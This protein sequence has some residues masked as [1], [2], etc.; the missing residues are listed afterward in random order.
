MVNLDNL[1]NNG[2]R[3]LPYSRDTWTGYEHIHRYLT[4][5]RFVHGKRVIDIACGEG[6]G[7]A[8]LAQSATHV[9]GIDID[10]ATIEHARAAHPQPNITFLEGDAARLTI[11]PDS[12]DVVVSFETLEHIEEQEDFLAALKVALAP[13]GLLIISTPNRHRYT[14]VQGTHNPYHKRELYLDEFT[15]LLQRHFSQV[16]IVGQ[17]LTI[18]SLIS[19]SYAGLN[20]QQA[21]GPNHHSFTT[22]VDG[23]HDYP[24][25][26]QSSVQPAY[27]IAWC[28][29]R[30][31]SAQIMND[32]LIDNSEALLKE[33]TVTRPAYEQK[34]TDELAQTQTYAHRIESDLALQMK[35][36]ERLREYI[37]HLEEEIGGHVT[38]VRSLTT[39]YEQKSAATAQIEQYAHTLEHELEQK[40]GHITEL[41]AYVHNLEQQLGQGPPVDA[42]FSSVDQSPA[43]PVPHQAVKD[44]RVAVIFVTYNS[45]A[46]IAVALEAVKQQTYPAAMLQTV[47]V[48]NHSH[49]ETVTLL[50]SHYPWVT[51]IAE[52][53]NHGFARGNN[54]A[55]RAIKADYYALVNADAVMH[56]RWIEEMVQTMQ[57]YP[58]IGVAGSKIFF[59]NRVLLQHTGGYL[60]AN[61][62]TYHTGA[63]ELDISQHNVMKDVD[64]VM[65]A[66]FMIRANVAEQLHYLPEAYFMYYEETEFCVRVRKA[67]YRVVYVPEAIAYH[68]ENFSQSKSFTDR[69]LFLY[70]RS[71]YL[72]VLRNMRTPQERR[73]YVEAERA[74]RHVSRN[75]LGKSRYLW[76]A[77]LS[78]WQLI[79]R[80][81][82]FWRS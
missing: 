16:H 18:T 21:E 66:A 14:D 59:G 81:P 26:K 42:S 75:G 50:R 67:G 71:R 48:D 15:A 82:W 70:H 78:H 25:D 49:D 73:E 37:S 5:A 79:L 55:M 36:I 29:N 62:L 19:A 43:V 39:E 69:F 41:E 2:E 17:T 68:D 38:A 6:Y 60:R 1:P 7:A 65:G 80:H 57:V 24:L 34:L 58:N 13:N 8:I 45:A 72:F 51:L 9:T 31:L 76:R 28:S 52:E 53:K 40:S 11:H 30:E 33:A 56:P 10:K 32:I 64:Y 61:A 44:L 77:K 54:I 27:F 20:P 3:Y 4:A 22:F 12:C 35:E 47:V 46:C 23:A 74:W 63:N